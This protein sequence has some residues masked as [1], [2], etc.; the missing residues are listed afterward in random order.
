PVAVDKELYITSFA[1]IVYKLNQEDGTVLSAVKNRATSAPVIVGEKVY[2]TRRADDGKGPVEEAV[3]GGQRQSLKEEVA[4]EKKNAP[5]LDKDVQVR[6]H[7]KGE[8]GALDAANGFAGGAPA[9][10]NPK[11]ADDNVGQSNV[12]SMQ[13]FQGSRILNFR[14]NNYNCM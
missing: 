4:G 9:A 2:L 12:S 6:A 14:D 3:S 10:A 1:G 8:A 11:A 13:A 7:L 5:Y